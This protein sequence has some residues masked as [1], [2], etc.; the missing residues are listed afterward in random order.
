LRREI[1]AAQLFRRGVDLSP[2]DQALC[3]AVNAAKRERVPDAEPVTLGG[4]SFACPRAA[5]TPF[6][7]V[8][9]SV[10]GKAGGL[11]FLISPYI[12]GPWAEGGYEVVVPQTAFRSLL[13]PAYADEFAGQP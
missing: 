9:S 1:G 8:P 13:A 6:V 5:D 11:R 4:G 3:E 12:V 10:G 7:L 2:L